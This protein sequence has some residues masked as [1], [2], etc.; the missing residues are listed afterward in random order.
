[1]TESLFDIECMTIDHEPATL[2]Q[3]R[4][5][6]ILV[7]NTA[8]FCGFTP[9]YKGLEHLYR[10]YRERGF[11]VLGFPS[12]DFIQEPMGDKRISEFCVRNYG[13]S[14]PMFAKVSIN[15]NDAAPLF[16]LLKAR[17]RGLFGSEAIK[18]NFTKFLIDRSG[19]V[20]G[21]Y[22]PATYPRRLRSRIES[23]LR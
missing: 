19:D 20:V 21:R 23:L 12:N 5:K 3:Y 10:T 2:E 22:G 1:M 18:W 17:A 15:G 13:V 6:V 9:Q 11:I 7:V 4:G 8:S 16:K 14:F